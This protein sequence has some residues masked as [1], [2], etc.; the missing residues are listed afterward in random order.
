MMYGMCVISN[1]VRNLLCTTWD[2]TDLLSGKRSFITLYSEICRS[3]NYCVIT[4]EVSCKVIPLDYHRPTRKSD[5]NFFI[6]SN[7][8]MFKSLFLSRKSYSVQQ[9]NHLDLRIE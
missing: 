1:D 7:K 5:R 2:R 9:T 3:P 4:P 6:C 8:D